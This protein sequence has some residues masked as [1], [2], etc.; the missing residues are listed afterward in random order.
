[1]NTPPKKT[2]PNAL[3]VRHIQKPALQNA[4][5]PSRPA[6]PPTFRPQ[7]IPRALQT[8]SAVPQRPQ[9]EQLPRRPIAQSKNPVSALSVKQPVAPP[10]YRPQVQPLIAQRKTA[11]G[12]L[13]KK[14]PVVPQVSQTK[15][16]VI[17][18]KR[19]G[20]SVGVPHASLTIQRASYAREARDLAVEAGARLEKKVEWVDLD[21][22]SRKSMR[23]FGSGIQVAL[24]IDDKPTPGSKCQ[25]CGDV[26]TAFELDHMTPWRHYVAAFVSGEYV[27]S[28]GGKI[29]VQKNMVKVL[30]NDPQNLWW[31]CRKC[32]NPKSDIIPESKEHAAGDFDEGTYGRHA[33]K[34]SAIIKESGK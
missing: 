3:L 16:N 21:T 4:T 7:Q 31:I 8:K 6:A 30:Y 9:T 14:P 23:W 19:S 34:P 5:A 17:Y 22:V 12:T 15:D 11:P 13:Q 27:K 18:P 1:M 29:L 28:S 26:A 24:G 32:N 33:M 25:N 2:K 20:P 10:I